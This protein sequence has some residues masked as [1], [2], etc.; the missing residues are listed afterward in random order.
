MRGLWQCPAL[1]M[2]MMMMMMMIRGK[3][4]QNIPTTSLPRF[5]VDGVAGRQLRMTWLRWGGEKRP[6]CNPRA[7]SLTM[8]I[9][10]PD[11]KSTTWGI[12]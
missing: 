1:M 2:M 3:P 11:G 5:Q 8:I 6:P 12:E 7:K 10:L 4:S 9:C